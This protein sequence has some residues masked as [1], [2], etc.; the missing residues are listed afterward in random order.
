MKKDLPVTRREIFGWCMFDFANSS[1]T[2]AIVTVIYSVYF[3]KIVCEGSANADL[4]WSLGTA[5]SQTVILLTAPVIGAL[6]DFSGSKKKFLFGTYIACVFFTSLLFGVERG[7]VML[8][9][10]FF[11]FSNIAFSMGENFNASFLPELSTP[12]NIGK[13]S[14]FGWALGYIGGMGSLLLCFPLIKGGFEYDNALNLR[15]TNLVVAGF[16]LLA[17]VPTFILLKERKKAQRLPPG[18]SY[19]TIGFK[20]VAETIRHI[21]DFKELAKFLLVFFVFNCGITSVIVFSSIFAEREIGFGPLD[22]MIFFII[23]QVTSSL[24]AFVFG[25]AQDRVGARLTLNITLILWIAV[26]IGAF[27]SYDK[28]S[29]YIVGNIA[30]LA[31]GSSQSASRALIG[32]FSPVEKTAEFFGFWG[33]FWKLSN[34]VGP[35]VFGITSSLVD[36]RTAILLTSVFFVGGFAGM[37]WIDQKEGMN[38]VI[39]YE[40]SH[41][42]SS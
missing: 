22:L 18:S 13:I 2:T 5:I 3:T 38:A 26:S 37:F 31:I 6:A 32:L 16:F 35:L 10:L 33:L 20:Q 23:V 8:G 39:R 36:S 9:I 30:G 27:F 17:A 7:D 25:F 1:Y 4:M 21:R 24:G 34:V 12:N 19:L 15:Y 14:G 41:P 11:I 42:P 40:Q 28:T 29:F